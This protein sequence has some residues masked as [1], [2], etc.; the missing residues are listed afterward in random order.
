MFTKMPT[1][2]PANTPSMGLPV[3]R[4]TIKPTREPMAARPSRPMCTK[5]ARW[6]YSSARDRKIRGVAIRM[7]AS[8]RFEMNSQLMTQWPPF[9]RRGG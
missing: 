7:L 5:P 9:R 2:A 1:N 6:E 4:L 3:I 8:S